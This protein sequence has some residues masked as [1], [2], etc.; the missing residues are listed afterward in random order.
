MRKLF[1][2]ITSSSF[3]Q[4]LSSYSI[5]ILF[6]WFIAT[7]F[8]AVYVMRTGEYISSQYF[9]LIFFIFSFTLF[10][11]IES[12]KV[13]KKHPW[14]LAIGS[15]LCIEFFF[16][17]LFAQYYY[18]LAALLLLLILVLRIWLYKKL[19]KIRPPQ[20]RTKR[21][22]RFCRYKSGLMCITVSVIILIVPS[23]T[24]MYKEYVDVFQENER[25][26]IVEEATIENEEGEEKNRKQLAAKFSA[27]DNLDINDR[28]LLLYEV[29]LNEEKYLG[30][31][32]CDDILITYEKMAQY[33]LAYYDDENKII[34]ININELNKAPCSE[35]IIS[36]LHEVFHAYQHD[37]VSSL[38]FDSDTVKNSYYYS[39]VREWKENMDNY[40]SGAGDY[41]GYLNQP[42][43]ASARAHSEERVFAYMFVP[44]N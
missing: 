37:L 19:L 25:T 28:F 11:Y 18:V 7:G 40:I 6:A 27:W 30:I 35:C 5:F 32:N 23:V 1:I 44:G 22:S 33:R 31:E 8:P 38:D 15:I 3:L 41:E 13:A 24:G 12:N 42:L 26:H 17:I 16:F 20:R 39:T 9:M 10:I 29:A 2:C 36:V 21:Y 34:S 14:M 4:K 43:E